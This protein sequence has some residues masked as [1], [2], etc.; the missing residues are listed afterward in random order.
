MLKKA[1]LSAAVGCAMLMSCGPAP[2]EGEENLD[3]V[4]MSAEAL[5]V[6]K[7]KIH[8][9]N[10]GKCLSQTAQLVDCGAGYLFEL[11][12]NVDANK[13]NYCVQGSKTQC[14]GRVFVPATGT[15]PAHTE[16]RMSQV[17]AYQWTMSRGTIKALNDG[18]AWTS[19]NGRV[20]LKAVDNTPAQ[21]WAIF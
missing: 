18:R 1:F 21:Q 9:G 10:T 15:T 3:V 4:D 19:T 2:E 17:S 14:L 5:T 8:A 12:S 13:D 7:F 6:G 20:Y 11:N 16:V